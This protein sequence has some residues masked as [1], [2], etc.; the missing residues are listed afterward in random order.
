VK[1][2]PT[3]TWLRD[4]R[5]EYPHWTLRK[6]VTGDAAFAFSKSYLLELHR[7]ELTEELQRNP[8]PVGGGARLPYPIAELILPPSIEIPVGD[9][10]ALFWSK[11]GDLGSGIRD[12]ASAEPEPLRREYDCSETF[13]SLFTMDDVP[14][15]G[16]IRERR[17]HILRVPRHH[18][19]AHGN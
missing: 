12:T 5:G 8:P 14:I 6:P 18:P 13:F 19:S 16:I 11:D 10:L 2:P 7:R 1:K 15:R 17:F 9:D 4:L 3:P